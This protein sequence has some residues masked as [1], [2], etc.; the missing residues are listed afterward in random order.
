MPR[1]RGR[2]SGGRFPLPLRIRRGY[3]LWMLSE[4]DRIVEQL[5]RALQG[6]TSARLVVLFGSFARGAQHPGSDLDVG[7]IP[8]DPNLSMREELALQGRLS[9]CVRCDVDLVRLDRA[10]PLVRWEVARAGRLV[11]CAEPR[12]YA[13]FIAAAALEHAEMEPL[14]RKAAALYRYRVLHPE[15]ARVRS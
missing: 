10:N 4:V 7:F 6:S 1:R 14:M 9:S 5:A 12:D 3:G 2:R 15:L 8:A 13:R 11:H